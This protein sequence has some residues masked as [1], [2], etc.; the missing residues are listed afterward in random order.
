VNRR[1]DQLLGP[2]G[3]FV[4]CP[5]GPDDGCGCR[6]PAPGLLRRAAELLG[7]SVE[8]CAVIGDIGADVE[9]AA[10]VGARSVLIPTDATRVEEISNAPAVA[11]RFD[12]AVDILLGA[13]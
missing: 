7:V 11:T 2:L 10:A 6:K 12:E 13:P 5:H 4:V 9:A 3:P 8:R 1:L